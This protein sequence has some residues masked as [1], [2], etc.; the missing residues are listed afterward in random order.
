MM[1][2]F[3]LFFIAWIIT[4]ILWIIA[5]TKALKQHTAVSLKYSWAMF[6]ISVGMIITNILITLF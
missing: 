6:V 5:T 3:L 2:L 4:F 1:V